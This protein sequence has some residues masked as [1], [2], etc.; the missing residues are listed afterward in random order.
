MW[1]LYPTKYVAVVSDNLVAVISDRYVAVISN[2]YVEAISYKYMA[3]IYNKYMAAIYDKRR[4]PKK[5][6]RGLFVRQMDIADTRLNWP[7]GQ[8]T[9]KMSE[10]STVEM[11]STR[12][13]N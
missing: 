7:L 3:A 11:T 13:A 10:H 8:F 9:E 6:G 2:N 12:Y 5:M 4:T 1:Q